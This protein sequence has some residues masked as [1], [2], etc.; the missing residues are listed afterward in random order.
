M[1]S[2]FF[3]LRSYG[4]RASSFH[5]L[6]QH[7]CLLFSAH[8]SSLCG[9]AGVH[10]D[11]GQ[12]PALTRAPL[13]PVPF[14]PAPSRFPSLTAREVEEPGGPQRSLQLFEQLCKGLAVVRLLYNLLQQIFTRSCL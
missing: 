5:I 8:P 12:E 13:L 2:F 4:S 9:E 3:P 10:S 11:P 6:Y 1:P 7:L 14:V